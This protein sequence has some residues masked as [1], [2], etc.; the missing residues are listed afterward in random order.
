MWYPKK[1][2]AQNKTW[3]REFDTVS[4]TKTYIRKVLG[5]IFNVFA[6]CFVVMISH[7]YLL[8]VFITF[9]I[10]MQINVLNYDFNLLIVIYL[11]IVLIKMYDQ[12]VFSN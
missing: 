8:C 12:N 4:K 1:L 11:Q 7:I 2:Q 3:M 6:I 9:V 5:T 10:N